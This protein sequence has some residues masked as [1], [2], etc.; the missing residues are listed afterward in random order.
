MACRHQNPLEEAPA[1]QEPPLEIKYSV[2]TG[3]NAV[4]LQ[5]EVGKHGLTL[6]WTPEKARALSH[7]IL[8]AAGIAEGF[9]LI[10]ETV[11]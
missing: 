4:Y 7:E 5:I 8:N 3:V 6:E 1:P 9:N 2:H 10:P 11:S